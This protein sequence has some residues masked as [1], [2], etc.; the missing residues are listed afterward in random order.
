MP[1]NPVHGHVHVLLG[2]RRTVRQQ[3]VARALA[4]PH[5]DLRNRV[6]T[7]ATSSSSSSGGGGAR[8]LAPSARLENKLRGLNVPL[9]P[10]L[11]LVHGLAVEG[12]IN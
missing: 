6:A 12:K 9:K 10:A 3:H 5:M 11:E 2:Q 4:A 1:K 8:G 7:R